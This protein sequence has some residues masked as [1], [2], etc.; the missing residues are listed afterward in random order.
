MCIRARQPG[1]PHLPADHIFWTL[2]WV[3]AGVL[4]RL[5]L[6]LAGGAMALDSRGPI[7][8]VETEAGRRVERGE[9]VPTAGFEFFVAWY[10]KRYPKWREGRLFKIITRA[11]SWEV[12][13]Q[14]L[15]EGFNSSSLPEILGQQFPGNLLFH[16][17]LY[18]SPSP[19]DATL[20]RMPSSA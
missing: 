9:F 11:S 18:T 10:V 13:F 6:E 8:A 12:A 16:C 19:R 2:T 17:L 7:C 4:L 3:Q 1:A 14:R 20:S 15:Q 5:C